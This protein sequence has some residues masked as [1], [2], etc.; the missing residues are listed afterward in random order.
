MIQFYQT[1]NTVLRKLEDALATRQ[2]TSLTFLKAI[3]E[4]VILTVG[5]SI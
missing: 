3:M 1:D 4:G 5:V 2:R